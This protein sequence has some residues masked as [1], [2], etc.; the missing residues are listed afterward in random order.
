MSIAF[1]GTEKYYRQLLET[2]TVLDRGAGRRKRIDYQR[3][4]ELP[5]PTLK[6][7]RAQPKRRVVAAV[8]DADGPSESDAGSSESPSPSALQDAPIPEQVLVESVA[9]RI[10]LAPLAGDEREKQPNADTDAAR[11]HNAKARR[12]GEWFLWHSHKFTKIK[13]NRACAM[14]FVLTIYAI[15]SKQHIWLKTRFAKQTHKKTITHFARCGLDGKFYVLDTPIRR[16]GQ[17]Q[18]TAEERRSG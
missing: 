17:G 6:R 14:L 8:C 2:H 4:D 5:Q 7:K 3:D 9:P 18:N 10:V 1:S 15:I 16:R 11:K 13:R 12:Y